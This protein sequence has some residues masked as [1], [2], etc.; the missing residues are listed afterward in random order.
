MNALE[1]DRANNRDPYNSRD[2]G[3]MLILY[4][5]RDV[6]SHTAATATA[7]PAL[8]TTAPEP[9]FSEKVV[10]LAQKVQVGPCIPLGMQPQK[11]V[12]GPT[13]GPTWCLSHFRGSPVAARPCHRV[14]AVGRIRRRRWCRCWRRRRPRRR[15]ASAAAVDVPHPAGAHHPVPHPAGAGGRRVAHARRAVAA[16]AAAVRGPVARPFPTPRQAAPACPAA[17]GQAASPSQRLLRKQ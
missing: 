11:A 15:A 4:T 8:P 16:A 12:V 9:T 10:R 2:G 17:S 7:T 13:S 3:P 14:G 6:T 1:H 5:T